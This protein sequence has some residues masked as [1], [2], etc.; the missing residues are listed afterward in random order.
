MVEDHG[1]EIERRITVHGWKG[2]GGERR[3]FH[4]TSALYTWKSVEFQEDRIG[5]NLPDWQPH[6]T[7]VTVEERVVSP[8]RKTYQTKENK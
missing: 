1:L 8:W 4:S 2:D 6:I 3:E 5:E 7:G